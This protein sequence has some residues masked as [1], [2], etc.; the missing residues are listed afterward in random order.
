M[1]GIGG[2]KT[3]HPLR[4]TAATRL[5][6]AWVDEQLIMKRTGHS[7]IEGVRVYK[8]ASDEQEEVSAILQSRQLQSSQQQVTIS[9]SEKRFKNTDCVFNVANCANVSITI[10]K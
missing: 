7:S 2:Y 5:Y 9:P 10:H 8:R 4:V 3:N 6:Q 1:V